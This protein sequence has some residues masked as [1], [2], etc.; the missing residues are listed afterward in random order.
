MFLLAGDILRRT[1]RRLPHKAAI[2]CEERRL[3]YSEFDAL[4]SRFANALLARGFR[5]GDVVGVMSPNYPEYAVAFYGAARAG[6]VVA[7]I[8]IRATA[9]DVAQILRRTEAKAIVVEA[10]VLPVTR[11]ALGS[12][13]SPPDLIPF[14]GDMAAL[15]GLKTLDQ[16]LR[17][18]EAAEPKVALE[19]NDPLGLTFTG[20]TTG[21]PKG[22][23]VSHRARGL[24]ALTTLVEYDLD[25]RD[26][27]AVTTPLFHAAG[28]YIWFHPAVMCGATSVFLPRWN[29]EAFIAAVERYGVTAAVLVPTQ[30][31]DLVKHPGFAPERLK[32]LHKINHAGMPMPV[33]LIETVMR[34]MPWVQL[35]ENYG[36]SETGPITA[37]RHFHLPAKATS[38]G[39]PVFNVEVEIRDPDGKPLPRGEVGEVVTRGDHLMIGYFKDP[40]ATSASYKSDD[41]WFWTGDLGYMDEDGFIVLVDRSKDVLVQGGENIFP[42]EIEQILYQ[43]PAV[44]ECAVFGVPDERLGEVPA[45]HVVARTGVAVTAEELV[46]FCVTRLARHKRPRRIELVGALPKTAVGKIQKH[47]IREAYWQGRDRKI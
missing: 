11:E 31:N 37:R 10:S 23:L 25:E 7:N 45:A 3:D 35:T 13:A 36:T 22:V 42:L 28:L 44:L 34:V 17:D 15:H 5:K 26:V 46:E 33:A 4:A 2:L 19:E 30:I 27:A 9:I 12:L 16:F 24:S 41:G 18:T 38:V 32:S 8:S 47:K 14:G 40:T 43:H 39:R 20:G 29:V 6:M 1:A 21:M